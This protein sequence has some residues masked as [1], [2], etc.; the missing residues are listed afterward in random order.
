MAMIGAMKKANSTEPEK[1]LP[2][3]A[4][5]NM[6]GVTSPAL[7]YDTRGDLKI[8]GITLYKVVKGKWET[9]ESV[10]GK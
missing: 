9:L 3:L 4:A 1:Y 8:G 2:A 7:G 10:G 5:T 6:P